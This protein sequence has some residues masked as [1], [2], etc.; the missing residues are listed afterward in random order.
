[1]MKSLTLAGIV[2]A[3]ASA[4]NVAVLDSESFAPAVAGSDIT[5]VKFYAPWCGH[6]KKIAPEFESASD[7]LEPEGISLAEVDCTLD[8]SKAVCSQYG[9]KGYPTLKVFRGEGEPTDYDGGRDEEG[10]VKYMRKQTQPAFQVAADAAALKVIT[11]ADNTLVAFLSAAEGADY[12]TFTTMA[13]A[14]RNDYNF[15]IVTDAATI[16]AEGHAA[17]S[18][19][20]YRKFDEPQVTHTGEFTKDALEAFLNNESMPIYGEIGPE[21]YSKYMEKGLP[22]AWCFVNYPATAEDDAQITA[23]AAQFKGQLSFVKLDGERWAQHGKSMG[24]NEFPGFAIAE[25]KKNFVYFGDWETEGIT[26]HSTGVLDGTIKPHMKSQEIPE[27]ND[28]AVVTLVGKNFEAVA[29]DNTKDVFVEFYAPWCGHCKSLAPKYEALA[30]EYSGNANVVIAKVDSTENDTPPEV[31][32][33]P[34]LFLFPAADDTAGIK[35]EGDRT[36][37]AMSEF[38]TTN[39][40]ATAA[41]PAESH[42]EL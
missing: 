3:T 8:E 19:V 22:I 26:A 25:G 4:H 42:D 34:T 5:L 14:L 24:I 33:F 37:E 31:S 1:M 39:G 41:A 36:Q 21:N 13:N 2:A 27:P 15:A 17:G 29:F 10:I 18:V 38:I 23:I 6:C 40:K 35:Y 30:E 7:I 12:D 11:D 28:E 20:F 32:G 16:E 9:V